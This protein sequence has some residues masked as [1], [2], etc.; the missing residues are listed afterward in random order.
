MDN[1]IKANPQKTS[2]N[3]EALLFQRLA[4]CGQNKVAER[5]GLSNSRLSRI[6][7]ERIAE[8]VELLSALNLTVYPDDKNIPSA[9]ETAACKALARL[10]LAE[11]E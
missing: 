2:R 9:E 5:L 3:L 4:A 10:Y 11:G 6:K 7:E 8:T 1:S